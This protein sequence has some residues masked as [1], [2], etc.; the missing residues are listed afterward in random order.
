MVD[1]SRG[2]V[3]SLGNPFLYNNKTTLKIPINN[4][5]QLAAI[6]EIF[7]ILGDWSSPHSGGA[8]TS[9]LIRSGGLRR[10][11]WESG[12]QLNDQICALKFGPMFQPISLCWLTPV[13]WY[14]LGKLIWW[15]CL[16]TH[17][18]LRSSLSSASTFLPRLSTAP[19]IIQ[20]MSKVIHFCVVIAQYKPAVICK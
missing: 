12:M 14:F 8:T 15:N 10:Y 17:V 5:W 1:P 20:H 11:C 4:V 2:R 9:T 13:K 3:L 7:T 16:N 18:S 6:L 19:S